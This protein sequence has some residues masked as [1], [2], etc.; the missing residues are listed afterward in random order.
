MGFIDFYNFMNDLLMFLK[1]MALNIIYFTTQDIFGRPLLFWLFG[2]G[3]ITY[4]TFKLIQ[5]LTGVGS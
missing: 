1:E 3:L 2:A 4:L 5:S